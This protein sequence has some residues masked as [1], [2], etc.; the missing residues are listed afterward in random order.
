MTQVKRGSVNHILVR[1]KASS[2]VRGTTRNKITK[3]EHIT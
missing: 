1:D 2:K 3:A